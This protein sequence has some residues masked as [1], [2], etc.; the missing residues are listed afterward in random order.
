MVQLSCQHCQQSFMVKPYLHSTAKYCSRQCLALALRIRISANCAVCDRHFEH[1]SSRCNRAKYCS[2]K[3][4]YRS[5]INRGSITYTCRHCHKTFRDAPSHKRIY[6]SKACVNKSA[7]ATWKP[8]F[9]T[10]RKDMQ[11]LGLIHECARCGY[12]TES[13]ILGIHHKD[14]NRRNN[15]LDNLEVL[16]PNCHSL[17]HLKHLPVSH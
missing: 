9:Q 3:C 11:R 7:K 17:E 8:A 5:Q 6:C 1:I 15:T 16:C 12:K 4:Y 13:R 10:V 14:R 2:R